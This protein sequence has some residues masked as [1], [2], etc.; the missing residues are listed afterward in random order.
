MALQRRF[1][2]VPLYQGNYEQKLADLADQVAS[3]HEAEQEAPRRMADTSRAQ[4]LAEQHDALRAE[5]DET[6]EHATLY[7][8]TNDQWVHL[9]AAHPPREGDKGD[10][11]RGVN[12][13]TMPDALATACLAP[14]PEKG[15]DKRDIPQL[16]AEGEAILDEL[17]DL[18][19]VQW[20]KLTRAAWA[21]NQTDDDLPKVSLVSALRSAR[22]SASEPPSASE[23]AP[24]SS[25]GGSPSSSTSTTTRTD[26][27]PAR[28]A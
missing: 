21:V 8:L 20:L 13:D 2:V 26:D 28:L 1:T 3:A 27:S 24:E 4:E 22:D 18:S 5:A 16:L 7:A 14:P 10:A 23:S 11:A 9:A 25:T 17:G 15:R 12:T 6:A 19:R